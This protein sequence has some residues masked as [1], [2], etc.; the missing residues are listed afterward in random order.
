[1]LEWVYKKDLLQSEDRCSLVLALRRRWAQ[2]QR[3]QRKRIKRFSW[4]V[5]ASS[6]KSLSVSVGVVYKKAH[7]PQVSVP[8]SIQEL[9]G[10]ERKKDQM[11]MLDK[12]VRRSWKFLMK[13]PLAISFTVKTESES[14]C[15]VSLT[16]LSISACLWHTAAAAWALVCS[17]EQLARAVLVLKQLQ[18]W[19]RHLL[20]QQQC[21]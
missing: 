4:H 6:S 7:Y 1:M 12:R 2:W 16:Y 15:H 13:R 11:E 10:R 21:S 17:I 9:V 19:M 18:N 20:V 14:P 8:K 3:Q 5:I